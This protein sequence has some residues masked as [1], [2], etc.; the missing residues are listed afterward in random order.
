MTS[1]TNSTD[2]AGS[3]GIRAGTDV[4]FTRTFHAPA[5]VVWAACTDPERMERWIGTWSGDPA[6]SQVNFRMTAEGDDVPEEP[7]LIEACEPPT[8]L[9]VRTRDSQPFSADGTGPHVHW[10]HT[11]VL[12]ETDGITTLRFSQ[13][14]P[15]GQLGVDVAGSVGPGWDYYLDR[16]AASLAGRDVA[17]VE[18]EPYL[19][20][21]QHYRDLFSR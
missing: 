12:T 11:L 18:F 21:T 19:A 5:S 16:L 20:R 8:R 4:V 15:D 13:V 10:Q 1:P 14:V 7:Y 17:A 3:L 9:V 6:S 2:T